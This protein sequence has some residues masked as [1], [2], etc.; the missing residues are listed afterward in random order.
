[1]S[2][3]RQGK[4]RNNRS[5]FTN[6]RHELPTVPSCPGG[7]VHTV[8]PGDTWENLAAQ[9]AVSVAALQH[10]NPQ[11]RDGDLQNTQYVCVPGP[12]VIP[13][14]HTGRRCIALS[15][16]LTAP[17]IS[18]AAYLNHFT[19]VVLVV[20]HGLPAPNAIDHCANQ[21]LLWLHDARENIYLRFALL[22]NRNSLYSA[23]IELAR[24]LSTIDELIIS[25][26]DDQVTEPNGW[27]VLAAD[28]NRSCGPF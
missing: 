16:T 6:Q 20:V 4:P 25:A 10:A 28:L 26:G 22:P 9:Y 17:E 15:R 18:G 2:R 5:R 13:D 1:M 8:Q 12:L 7:W 14:D 24:P 27:R 19:N 23:R 3:R 21:W 11:I